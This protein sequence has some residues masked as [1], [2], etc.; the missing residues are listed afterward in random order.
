MQYPPPF[1]TE[2]FSFSEDRLA[3]VGVLHQI[4]DLG[5]PYKQRL[6]FHRP[7]QSIQNRSHRTSGTVG[8]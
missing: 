1:Q 5:L 2:E 7:I 3:N 6:E 4:E 8:V